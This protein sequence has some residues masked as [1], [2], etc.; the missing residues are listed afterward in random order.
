[1]PRSATTPAGSPPKRLGLGVVEPGRRLVEE[2]E[3]EPAGDG[4][5]QLDQAALA[6]GQTADG[7]G[8][9]RARCRTAPGRSRSPRRS[10]LG[11]ASEQLRWRHGRSP[12]RRASRPRA[13][14]SRTVSESNSSIRWNVRPRPSWARRCGAASVT[15]VPARCTCPLRRRSRPVQ[16][17]NVVVLPAPFGPIRPV[18]CPAGRVEGDAV[19][20]DEPTEA[21]GQ[22]VHLEAA[23]VTHR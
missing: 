17:L 1:M 5:G 9:Q 4:P 22:V 20:G 15:S 14:F 21:H 7:S 23:G 18:I 3:R 19:D 13:T 12:A 2:Q 16:A 11:P 6:G 8:R 10:R